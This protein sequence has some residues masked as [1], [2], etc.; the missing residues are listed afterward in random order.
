MPNI[1]VYLSSATFIGLHLQPFSMAPWY[2]LQSK[3][4]GK[5]KEKWKYA[6]V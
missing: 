6:G 4:K 2:I 1:T 3:Q 5:V